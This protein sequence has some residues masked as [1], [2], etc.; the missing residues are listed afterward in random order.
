MR[1]LEAGGVMVT[2]RSGGRTTM[3]WNTSKALGAGRAAAMLG[4]IGA[5]VM[6][7]GRPG[8]AQSSN[9]ASKNGLEGTWFVQVTLRNCATNAQIGLPFNSLVTFHRGGTIS[10]STSS[11]AFAIGQR[12]GGQGL[13]RA[14]GHHTYSQRMVGLINFDTPPNLPVSPGFFAGWSTV[15]HTLELTDD[16]HATSSG[17]NEFYKADGT[18]YRS[19][20]STAVAVR[21]E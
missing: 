8:L 12:G 21:F 2:R 14:A 9:A 1:L 3:N 7:S 18:L 10:E 13:W 19:G 11:P 6:T 4:L 16:D 15:S 17:T 5:L 20:C